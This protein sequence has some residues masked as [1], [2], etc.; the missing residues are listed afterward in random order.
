MKRSLQTRTT[1]FHSTPIVQGFLNQKYPEIVKQKEKFT[2]PLFPPNETSLYSTKQD[3]IE[4]K[5][6]EVPSF[7][8]EAG[9]QENSYLNLLFLKEVTSINGNDFLK[10]II[11]E[12]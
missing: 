7:L 9:G 3:H 12:T 8:K 5:P 10:Y 1:T 11:S 2:D 4:F 6:I